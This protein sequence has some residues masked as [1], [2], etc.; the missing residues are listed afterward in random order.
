MRV[1]AFKSWFI[2]IELF[3]LVS[4]QHSWDLQSVAQQWPFNPPAAARWWM[5]QT[6]PNQNQQSMTNKNECVVDYWQNG[7]KIERKLTNKTHADGRF[8]FL[9]H[10]LAHI[11]PNLIKSSKLLQKRWN[12]LKRCKS[13][14]SPI[15]PFWS[16]IFAPLNGQCQYIHDRSTNEVL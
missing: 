14:S 4:N 9:L 12:D 15:F 1:A 8:C 7:S 10:N 3:L 11:L 13:Q 5:D 2:R 6:K 16:I